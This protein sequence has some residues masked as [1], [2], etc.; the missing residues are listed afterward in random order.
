M[1]FQAILQRQQAIGQAI[2]IEIN[3][4]NELLDHLDQDVD[5]TGGKLG[6]AKRQMVSF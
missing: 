5:R 1:L 4:Q 6:R 3:E 2:S